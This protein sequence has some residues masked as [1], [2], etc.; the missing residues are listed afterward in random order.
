MQ[1][2][3]KRQKIQTDINDDSDGSITCIWDPQPPTPGIAPGGREGIR[4]P[5]M[6]SQEELR[7]LSEGYVLVDLFFW[8]Y[9]TVFVRFHFPN[10]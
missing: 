3:S 6:W 7:V 10:S 5:V 4:D 9:Y 1:G 8:Y 2:R